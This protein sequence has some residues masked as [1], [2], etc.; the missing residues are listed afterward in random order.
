MKEGLTSF[1]EQRDAFLS[2]AASDCISVL[3]F[4]RNGCVRVCSWEITL[5][6]DAAIHCLQSLCGL[7]QP[8]INTLYNLEDMT[9][10]A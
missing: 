1:K 7:L 9:L 3:I 2:S 10:L 4:K 6:L 5:L 8:F